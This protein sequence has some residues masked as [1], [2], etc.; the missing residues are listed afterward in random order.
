MSQL[1]AISLSSREDDRMTTPVLNRRRVV[2]ALAFYFLIP[3]VTPGA[4]GTRTDYARAEQLLAWNARALVLHDG[5]QPQW[6]G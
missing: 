5:V 6:I 2:S 1:R 3:N 4:Q